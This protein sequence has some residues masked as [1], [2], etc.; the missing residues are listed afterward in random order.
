[1]PKKSQTSTG[2]TTKFHK[3][4]VIILDQAEYEVLDYGDIAWNGVMY[5]DV[6]ILWDTDGYGRIEDRSYVEEKAQ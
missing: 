4:D 5:K 2:E 3:G 1:M 6:Y